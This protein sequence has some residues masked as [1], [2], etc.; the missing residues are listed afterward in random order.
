MGRLSLK[1]KR[2]L[3]TGGNGYLGAHLVA[4]LQKEGAKVFIMDQKT[5]GAE[6]EFAVNITSR[7]EVE[8]AIGQIR[9]EVIYHLAASLN[10]DRDFANHDKV[11]QVNY[12]GTINLLYSLQ[13][14]AYENFIFTS[15]SEVYGGNKAPFT[16]K[17]LPDPASPYSL[18]KFFAETAI[19]TFSQLHNKP[20]TILRLFNF[21]GKNMPESF[22]IPQLLN[23]LR[24]E[25]SFKMTKGAQAR[26]F[27]Y[28]NDI[29][30]ALVLAGINPKA[31]NEVFNVCSGKS[32]TLRQLVTEFKKRV[33]GKCKIEFGAL[34]Y[35]ENEVWNMVGSNSKIKSKLGFKV[36]YNTRQAIDELIT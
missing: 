25:A 1:N 12:Y 2:I 27:L 19:R 20:F 11:M 35:R 24:N 34:P 31:R 17:Q 3:V 6:N 14:V 8:R 13:N 30:Q 29:I 15:T 16:E 7:E 18:S 36:K 10:R 28:V 9:P 33:K 26:D 5:T 32:T 4:A 22:F 23:S 21:F